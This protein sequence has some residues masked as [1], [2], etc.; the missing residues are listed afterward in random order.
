MLTEF[1]E[2]PIHQTPEPLAFNSTGDRNAYERCWFN[3]FATDGSYFFGL[4]MGYYPN[5]GII[6]GAFSVY[7]NGA[8]QRCVHISARSQLHGKTVAGP[9]R[10]DFVEPMRRVHV[11]LD[12]NGSGLGCDM[13]FSTRSA[14]VLENRQILRSGP[15]RTMDATRYDQFGRWEG[16]ITTPE[17][18][19]QVAD[20]C[21][22][23]IKDRSWGVRRFGEAEPV[24]PIK[25]HRPLFLWTPIFWDDHVSHA[26]IFDDEL[27][28]ALFREGFEAPLYPSTE[29][30]PGIEDG[31]VR[32]MRAVDH[33]V[34]YTQGTRYAKA[35]EIDL[36][37]VTGQSRTISLEP[38]LRF[39]QKGIG[40]GHSKWPHG[41]WRG[42]LSIEH[43]S[44]D[45][46][47]LDP[48]ALDNIHVQHV[49]R[50]RDDSGRTGIGILEEFILGAYAPSGF[51]DLLEKS[52]T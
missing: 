10:I 50:A 13:T 23:G 34:Q 17:G 52:R 4:T 14:A 42:D 49:V 47:M 19:I 12:D 41:V 21:C 29:A 31:K 20:Q 40:Y 11:T 26:I 5:R 9:L 45:P 18:V 2:F 28:H 24:G 22:Y 1:D 8:L 6:D 36:V 33:R 15:R 46:Q 51:E 3:G 16:T 37:S 35:A 38:I 48:L 32:H 27:G 43:E 44:F 30:V 7:R 39:Q 25:G